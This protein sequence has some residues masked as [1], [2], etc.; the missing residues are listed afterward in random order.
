MGSLDGLECWWPHEVRQ[1]MRLAEWSRAGNRRCD[2]SGIEATS[3]IDKIAT[4]KALNRTRILPEQTINLRELL[5]GS[6][7]TQQRQFD[8]HRDSPLCLTCFS[9]A[10]GGA[11]SAVKNRYQTR[12]SFIVAA[13]HGCLGG[14]LCESATLIYQLLYFAR[15]CV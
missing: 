14:R 1:G 6:V 5:S 4:N 11:R 3:G 13:V 9:D 10:R 7:G 2:T 8:C 12:W 15:E